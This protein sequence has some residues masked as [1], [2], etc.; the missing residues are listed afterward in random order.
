[1]NNRRGTS[2]LELLVLLTGCAAFISLSGQLLHRALRTQSESRRCFDGQR[3]AWRLATDFRRDAHAA[4]AATTTNGESDSPEL[5]RL[6]LPEGRVVVYGREGTSVVRKVARP[7]GPEARE[8]Y[9]LPEGSAASVRF[10]EESRLA[11]LS[12]GASP[13]KAAELPP[14]TANEAT[15]VIEIAALVGRD[16]RFAAARIDGEGTP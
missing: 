13:G 4:T 2:L 11:T 15:L 16:Y 8:T 14:T 7:N 10:H 3:T 12:I 5:L 6:T 9:A 1:M